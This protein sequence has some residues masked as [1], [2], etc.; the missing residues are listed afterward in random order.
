[1]SKT[2][3]VARKEMWGYFSSPTA[4]IFLGTYL[5]VS[6]FTFFWVE[7]FFS[8]NIADMRPLFE[9]MP[10]LMIFL[11]STLTMK[12][13]SE[14][15]RSGTVEFLL[16]LPIK[17]HELVLGKFL[18]C[19]G[20]VSIGLAMTLCLAFSVSLLGPMDWGPVIGAY[21]ASLLL[22]GAYTSI[23]L[24]VSSKTNSQIVSLIVTACICM[25]MYVVG[26]EVIV[27]FFG[28]QAGQLLKLLGSGARF[29]SISRGVLDFRDIYYSKINSIWSS[30]LH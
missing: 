3:S 16:T 10:L 17:T 29:S 7:K 25:L 28:N 27:G 20:L 14:E 15:R 6:L 11:V 26:S 19:M 4:L 30:Y 9:W 23:G 13:W 1:M 5:F 2:L 22:A 12:M 18:A 8:R 24:F 21:I